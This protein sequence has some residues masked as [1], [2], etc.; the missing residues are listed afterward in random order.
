MNILP[1]VTDG[2]LLQS[3]ASAVE[4]CAGGRWCVFRVLTFTSAASPATVTRVCVLCSSDL[5]RCGFY[6]K[7]G[8]YLC[9]ADFQHLYGNRC[10]RCGDYILGDVVSVL[11]HT[12]HPACFS[13]TRCSKPF[14]VGGSVTFS[15]Q[16]SVCQDCISRQP[17]MI[18]CH[19]MCAGCGEPIEVGQSLLA[20]EHQWHVRCFRCQI[21]RQPITR[22]YFSRDG[23]PYCE[24][25]YH[26]QF[27][28]RCDICTRFITGTVLEVGGR[29]F[30]PSCARCAHCHHMFLEGEELYLTV[31][32]LWHPECKKAERAERKLRRRR[33]SETSASSSI[34]SPGHV[35]RVRLGN[36]CLDYKTVAALPEDK[37]IHEMESPVQR[38]QGVAFSRRQRSSSVD[39]YSQSASPPLHYYGTG[40]DSGRSSPYHNQPCAYYTPPTR[41]KTPKHFHLPATGETNIYGKPPIYKQAVFKS[42]CITN[43]DVPM[44]PT[45]PKHQTHTPRSP[46][47]CAQEHGQSRSRPQGEVT[48]QTCSHGD[49]PGDRPVTCDL[50]QT[51]MSNYKIYPYE[52]LIV[53]PSKGSRQLPRD[54]DRPRLEKHLSHEE[55]DRVFGMS[56]YEFEHLPLWKRKELKKQASLF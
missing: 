23:R 55:F 37:A 5:S 39:S 53:S 30:H 41:N 12:Y 48:R 46:R 34:G 29:Q 42:Q 18:H 35:I 14:P 16:E 4:E 47:R 8:E 40:S 6:R 26:T 50:K 52:D 27:G 15:G 25:D 36:E 7:R 32:E 11:G 19:S 45:S 10:S 1:V 43:D 33:A 20:L 24:V 9:Q 38:H 13:C 31:A 2:A 17:I 54:V 44:M 21:C 3:D 49:D 56:V 51:H 22:E 28:I